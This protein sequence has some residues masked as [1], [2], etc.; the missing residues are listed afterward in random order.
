MISSNDWNMLKDIAATIVNS[1]VTKLTAHKT[2]AVI[3]KGREIGWEP[4]QSLANIHDVQ[5]NLTISADGQLALVRKSYPDMNLNYIQNDEKACVVEVTRVEGETN[6]FSFTMDDANQARLTSK[7]TWKQYPRAMLRSRVISEMARAMFPDALMGFKY[8]VDEVR[9]MQDEPHDNK[10]V[11]E[12][13]KEPELKL[14]A[15]YN[16][17][18]P[19]HKEY[20]IAIIKN[21]GVT[22]RDEMCNINELMIADQVPLKDIKA[23]LERRA[24]EG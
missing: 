4:M 19:G 9:D 7:S 14:D 11:P 13:P 10:T 3:L 16:P 5:G 2:L 20:L 18:T 23:R 15:A 1:G 8:N 22:D 21:V 24:K 17:K 12:K 6:T